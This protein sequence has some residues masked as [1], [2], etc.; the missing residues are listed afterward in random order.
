M[1][2]NRDKIDLSCAKEGMSFVGADR[3]SL[4]VRSLEECNNLCRDTEDCKSFSYSIMDGQCLLKSKRGG[5]RRAQ[6][7]AGYTSMNMECDNNEVTNLDCLR[8]GLNFDGANL[9]KFVRPNVEECV[10]ECR[11]TEGC[12][13]LTFRD[14]DKLCYLKSY[15]GGA[16]GPTVAVG[17]NS[18]NMVCDSST[19]TN[20]DCLRKGLNFAGANLRNLVVADVKE[21]V[22][23]CRDTEGCVALT[24]Q[25]SGNNCYLKSKR[26]GKNGPTVA[27]GYNSMNMK[28]GNIDVTNLSCLRKGFTFAGADLREYTVANVAECVRLCTDTEGCVGLTFRESDKRCYLKSKRGGF[29][30]PIVADGHSSMNMVCDNSAVTNLDCIRKRLNF[31]GADLRNLIVADV[32]E[33]VRLCRDTDGCVAL[34][35]R[36]YDKRCYLKAN[37]GG[38]IGPIVAA[39]HSS[40]NMVCDN[41]PVT[42][43]G[44]LRKGFNFAGADLRDLVAADVEKCV[45]LCRDTEGCVALTFRESDK[46]C[47]LKSRRGG[48]IGPIVAAGHNSMNMKCDNSALTNLGCMRKGIDFT[49]FDLRNITVSDDKECVNHCRD[50][51]GCV[52]LTFGEFDK[53]CYLKSKRGG[54][55]GPAAAAGYNSMNMLCDNSK[56]YLRCVQLDYEFPRSDMKRLILQN[57]VACITICRDTQDCLSVS[58]NEDTNY[59]TLKSKEFDWWEEVFSANVKSINLAYCI[60]PPTSREVLT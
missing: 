14:S 30:G 51:E 9:N 2:C 19:L 41:S 54:V 12:V 31:A 29:L 6:A 34:T 4:V 18:M 33:C 37:R 42:N 57:L 47:Y 48:F 11:D 21:C 60:R 1:E 23:L 7:M 22:R 27:A 46:R 8:K 50:T 43:L 13:A 3:G 36:E 55:N 39:G 53:R 28:C 44:C 16:I 58:Y 59:C 56:I 35:F 10:K 32:E 49:G 24:F 26:G 40:M 45:M 5:F 17:Y 15:R 38:F 52:A 25:E 20:L